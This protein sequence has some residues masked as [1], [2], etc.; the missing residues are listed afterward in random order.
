MSL[1]RVAFGYRRNAKFEDYLTFEELIT[2]VI[3]TVAYGGTFKKIYQ[4][5]QIKISYYLL[6]NILINIGPAHDGTIDMIFQERLL[7]LGTWLAINGEA[8]YESHPWTTAQ[9]DSLNSNVYY[10]T[11]DEALYALLLNW[12]SGSI[13]RLGSVL[14]VLTE[15]SNARVSMLGEEEQLE[16]SIGDDGVEISLP[17]M[18]NVQ[19]KS[20]WVIKIDLS[21]SIQVVVHEA[22]KIILNHYFLILSL[23]SIN[24]QVF[25]I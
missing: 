1:D 23:S 19:S 6:G 13:L 7:Q 2:T 17:D 10:T 8:I 11:K 4:I 24:K 22:I 25:T 21:S 15:Y 5:S 3:Q 14:S 18:A 20:A 12:P 16:W 9:Q